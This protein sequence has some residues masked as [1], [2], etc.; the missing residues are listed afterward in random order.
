MK[1]QNYRAGQR[2]I[3]M[4][5]FTLTAEF[6]NRNFIERKFSRVSTPSLTI[7]FIIFHWCSNWTFYRRNIPNNAT[8]AQSPQA[9]FRHAKFQINTESKYISFK[10]GKWILLVWDSIGFNFIANNCF[11]RLEC[12]VKLRNL[13]SGLVAM[14]DPMS[15]SSD[16]RSCCSAGRQR[17]FRRKL[18]LQQHVMNKTWRYVFVYPHSSYFYWFFIYFMQ[19]QV[20]SM[21]GENARKAIGASQDTAV[22][23]SASSIFIWNICFYTSA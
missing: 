14:T 21:I 12:L 13:Q 16:A 19:E 22:L 3:D 7:P 9:K 20:F 23:M 4:W 2:D 17:F 10:Q 6:E 1:S 5:Q 18:M 11:S 8:C 15:T